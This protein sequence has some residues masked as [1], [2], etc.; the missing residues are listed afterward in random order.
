MASTGTNPPN[1]ANASTGGAASPTRLPQSKALGNRKMKRS[2]QKKHTTEAPSLL[3]QPQ[4]PRPGPRYATAASDDDTDSDSAAGSTSSPSPSRKKQQQHRSRRVSTSP[5]KQTQLQKHQLQLLDL[6]DSEDEDNLPLMNT[7]LG[8]I[9]SDEIDGPTDFTENIEYW[10]K[11]RLP[12]VKAPTSLEEGDQKSNLEEWI[13]SDPVDASESSIKE[14]LQDDMANPPQKSKTNDLHH[15]ATSS[16][17]FKLIQERNH[18]IKVLESE[19]SESRHRN[20]S[21]AKE[22]LATNSRLESNL[23]ASHQANIDLRNEVTALKKSTEEMLS[24]RQDAFDAEIRELKLQHQEELAQ[25]PKSSSS[26]LAETWTANVEREVEVKKLKSAITTKDAKLEEQER[27]MRERVEELESTVRIKDERFKALERQMGD[28]KNQLNST[29]GELRRSQD[30]NAELQI[31]LDNAVSES[32]ISRDHHD[33]ELKEASR[34]Y[35]TLE[36]A[37]ERA[38]KKASPVDELRQQL[39]AMEED[40]EEEMQRTRDDTKTQLREIRAK[41]ETAVKK[42]GELLEKER[43]EVLRL[44]SEMLR[45][46]E[47]ESDVKNEILL[48][49]DQVD[50]LTKE[51]DSFK[52][53][54]DKVLTALEREQAV[55]KK[56]KNASEILEKEL[57]ELKMLNDE[58]EKKMVAVIAEREKEWKKRLT[59]LKSEMEL[60]SKLLMIEWG[61][62]EVGV[63][64]ENLRVQG[65]KYLFKE[66]EFTRE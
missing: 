9:R 47:A 59:E 16:E 40:H 41:A 14:R 4:L 27:E 6:E 48:L 7:N 22:L 42:A 1:L 46:E 60:R 24:R 13:A 3:P 66:G 23:T 30:T 38:E 49:N 5:S 53:K 10:M 17:H 11:A 43:R 62:R 37:A 50:D 18:T 52:S 55:T 63:D 28:V 45:I 44:K 32:Q 57:V 58:T 39:K 25:R 35:K 2:Q 29:Q 56:T 61:R 31:Q 54:L 64:K 19:L 8:L 36:Q 12:S 51:R 34:R 21:A 26:S 33:D 15:P 65:Y 20:E